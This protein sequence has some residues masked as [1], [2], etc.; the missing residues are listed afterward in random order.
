MDPTEKSVGVEIF[1]S[2]IRN[3]ELSKEHIVPEKGR[4]IDIVRHYIIDYSNSRM[5]NTIA[6]E[7]MTKGFRGQS[8][9]IF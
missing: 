1:L 2:T 6:Y 9:L 7:V 3:D 5:V 4:L 8:N